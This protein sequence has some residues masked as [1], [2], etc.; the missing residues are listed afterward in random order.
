MD[1]SRY[2]QSFD[3]WW[4]YDG[5]M[6]TSQTRIRRTTSRRRYFSRELW[7]IGLHG[8]GPVSRDNVWSGTGVF[9]TYR[10]FSGHSFFIRKEKSLFVVGPVLRSLHIHK[11]KQQHRHTWRYLRIATAQWFTMGL[12]MQVY[13]ESLVGTSNVQLTPNVSTQSSDNPFK[14]C[15]HLCIKINVLWTR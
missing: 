13:W 1:T 10:T 7:P 6:T 9:S 5:V 8:P 4:S 14:D 3:G 12:G 2:K 15:W 11:I